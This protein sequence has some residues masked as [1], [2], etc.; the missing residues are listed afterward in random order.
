M[1]NWHTP[2]GQFGRAALAWK[3]LPHMEEYLDELTTRF[4]H[5]ESIRSTKKG[6]AHF[7]LFAEGQD[8]EHPAEI[9]R[10]HTLRFLAYLQQQGFQPSY[11]QRLAKYVKSWTSW[12]VDVYPEEL[13]IDPWHKVKIGTTKKEPDPLEDD[14]VEALF[15]AHRRQ[16]FQL[17]PFLFHRREVIL[18]TFFGWGLRIH[19]LQT[20]NCAQMDIRLDGVKVKNKGAPGAT[21]VM[22]Y[23]PE[24]KQVM[25]RWFPVR[26]RHA[27]VGEDALLIEQS[28]GR[29]GIDSIR[30][31]I[32][33]L[34][35]AAGVGINP[36]RIRDTVG[37]KMLTANVPL[38]RVAKILGHSN[39]NQTRQYAAVLDV[40][41]AQDHA[42]VI[43][44]DLGDLIMGRTG[45]LPDADQQ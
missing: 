30:K 21:K 23:G 22:P 24:M 9:E 13:G 19:E 7:G 36:H 29:L 39:I 2:K 11:Q 32:I 45:D 35:D 26:G 33:A 20:V 41:V 43:D 40:A 44:H 17:S 4:C 37:T 1:G 25:Q 3:P 8:I 27:I 38:E 15:D 12:M 14:E 10:K 28:G 42:R 34:G 6:L 5:P 18:A 31:T 16:A